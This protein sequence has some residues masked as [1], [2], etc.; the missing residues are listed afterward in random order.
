MTSFCSIT[1]MEYTEEN[2]NRNA[3]IQFTLNRNRIIISKHAFIS[4]VE[5]S[6][7]KIKNK[8]SIR[9]IV[10]L[11]NVSNIKIVSKKS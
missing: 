3:I 8:N 4:H 11:K 2:P 6:R 1:C 10:F 9:L 5:D 7:K